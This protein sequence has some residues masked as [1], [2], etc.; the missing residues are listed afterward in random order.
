[1]SITAPS[2]VTSRAQTITVNA[3]DPDNIALVQVR[4]NNGAWQTAAA[5]GTSGQY[6]IGLTLNGTA[7]ASVNNAV[8][9]RATDAHANPLTSAIV[10]K[11][12][13]VNVPS[14]SSNIGPPTVTIAGVT[15]P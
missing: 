14:G 6:S 8:D 10:S 9:A 3:T 1:M 4:L 15:R 7:G 5:T 11:T 12:I 13:T 2:P